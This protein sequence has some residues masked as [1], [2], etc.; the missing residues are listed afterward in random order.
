MTDEIRWSAPP[1]DPTKVP[2]GADVSE[3]ANRFVGGAKE[4]WAHLCRLAFSVKPLG[5]DRAAKVL[6]ESAHVGAPTLKRKLL[7][8]QYARQQ[9]ATL[10]QVILLGQTSVMGGYV[11][12]KKSERTDEQ[13]VLQW[14]VEPK[15]RDAVKKEVLRIAKALGFKTSDEFWLWMH[16]QMVQWTYEELKHSAGEGQPPNAKR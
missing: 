11:N 4:Q 6:S 2:E 13:V 1:Q 12:G 3:I 16:A 7:A 8:I 14:K 5:I 15:L 10:D 9:G